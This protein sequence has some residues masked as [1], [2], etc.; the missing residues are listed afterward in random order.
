M[1][2]VGIFVR[3]A[4]LGALVALAGCGDDDAAGPPVFDLAVVHDLAPRVVLDLTITSA[5]AVQVGPGGTNVFAPTRVTINAG[6]SVTWN[7][8]SGSH[9]IV[10]DDMPPAFAPSWVRSAGQFIVTFPSAGTFG[11]HCGVHGTMMTG[12]VVVK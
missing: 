2:R 9:S 7:W 8:V 3:L 11:Y 1:K 6:E 5:A 10:S 12:T 4:G